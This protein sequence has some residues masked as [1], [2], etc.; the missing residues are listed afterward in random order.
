MCNRV[1]T[2]ARSLERL[3]SDA[4]VW[5]CVIDSPLAGILAKHSVEPS[6]YAGWIFGRT[7]E[8]APSLPARLQGTQKVE[9][10]LLPDVRER[11]EPSDDGVG[12]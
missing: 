6:N 11:V 9:D 2:V 4:D 12:F 10:V 8:S 7:I 3:R 5:I 1:V